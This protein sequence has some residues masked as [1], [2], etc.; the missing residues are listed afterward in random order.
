MRLR[1]N[2]FRTL[3]IALAFTFFATAGIF[4]AAQADRPGHGYDYNPRKASGNSQSDNSNDRRGGND[5][6]HDTDW[7]QN[8]NWRQENADSHRRDSDSKSHGRKPTDINKKDRQA[9]ASYLQDNK[10][11]RCPPGLAKKNNGCLPP[12]QA[13]KYQIGKRLPSNVDVTRIPYS[14]RQYLQQPQPG[15]EYGRVDNDVLMM[16]KSDRIVVDAV[17]LLTDLSR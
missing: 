10:Y 13:K 5:W 15:Y 7:G 6:S 17:T 12:G 4:A 1:K 2:Q 14:L 8:K 9:I 11:R 16:S 3:G